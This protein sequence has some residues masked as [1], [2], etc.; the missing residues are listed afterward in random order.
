MKLTSLINNDIKL[1][2]LAK[3]KEKLEALRAVKTAFTL[4]MAA[5][6]ATSELTD[7]EEISIIKKLV[8]QRLDAAEIY[9]QQNR[10]DLAE[11]EQNQVGVLKLY[12][13]QEMPVEELT[14]LIKEIIAQCG[15]TSAKEMGKVMGMASKQLQGKADNKA[16]SEIIKNL[17]S[18]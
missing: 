17:L 6:S 12:L 13:P 2:M 5:K 11:P 16:I 14:A 18:D 10:L 8:K 7:D 15:A 3:D 4:A 1:A 9:I